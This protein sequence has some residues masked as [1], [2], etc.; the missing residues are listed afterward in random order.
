MDVHKFVHSCDYMYCIFDTEH[1][2]CET[3]LCVMLLVLLQH[4]DD[5]LG[6]AESVLQFFG[7]RN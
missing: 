6:Q 5:Q 3:H 1:V 4:L 7:R 2:M